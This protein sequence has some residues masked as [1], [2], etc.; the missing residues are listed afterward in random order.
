MASQLGVLPAS[1]TVFECQE[2]YPPFNSSNA[3]T[4]WSLIKFIAEVRSEIINPKSQDNNDY[5]IPANAEVDDAIKEL[6]KVFALFQLALAANDP[7]AYTKT[8]LHIPAFVLFLNDLCGVKVDVTS[9]VVTLSTEEIE[10]L[11]KLLDLT[12]LPKIPQALNKDYCNA[13]LKLH[14]DKEGGSEAEFKK[15]SDLYERYSKEIANVADSKITMP[16]K[17]EIRVKWMDCYRKVCISYILKKNID[18]IKSEN[19]TLQD[20]EAFV[21]CLK[22]SP[23]YKAYQM[24]RELLNKDD[25]ISLI[26]SNVGR[27]VEALSDK[28]W[29]HNK[30]FLALTFVNIISTSA[31]IMFPKDTSLMGAV[32]LLKDNAQT[33]AYR[34]GALTL[35][36]GA[37]VATH[38]LVEN[39][40][41]NIDFLAYVCS[42]MCPI[43]IAAQVLEQ[44]VCFQ[45]KIIGLDIALNAAGIYAC[46]KISQH[47]N[48][49][50]ALS[51]EQGVS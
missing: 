27:C 5:S 29:H 32:I 18:R 31:A 21:L 13:A 4:C 40:H 37:L 50:G 33:Y 41:L 28:E 25:S 12:E 47:Y 20:E 42:L 43:V 23:F 24:Y 30:F 3:A 2:Y 35:L 26:E 16:S 34:L 6:D 19:P 39:K 17:E 1:L 9:N 15:L 11:K 51:G 46:Y 7:D 44:G 38:K 45:T 22:L 48:Q 49:I 36:C 14:L 10:E 8:K